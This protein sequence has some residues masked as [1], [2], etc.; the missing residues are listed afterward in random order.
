MNPKV[1]S[2]SVKVA[3]NKTTKLFTFSYDKTGSADGYQWTRLCTFSPTGQGGD[4]RG[5][6]KMNL[7]GGAFK[8]LLYG[9]SDSQLVAIGKAFFDNFSLKVG[10]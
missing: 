1:A 8:V 9:Y 4:R 3:F 7:A 6:W 5:D 2:G 10:N